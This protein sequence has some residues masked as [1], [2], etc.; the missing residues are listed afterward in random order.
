M[1]LKLTFIIECVCITQSVTILVERT[2]ILK[3]VKNNC[4]RIVE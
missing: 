2:P 4:M 1:Y 3:S